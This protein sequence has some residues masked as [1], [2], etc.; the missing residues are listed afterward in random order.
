MRL[1]LVFAAACAWA[2]ATI[3]ARAADPP[4]RA[5]TLFQS[6][7]QAMDRGDY[8]MACAALAESLRLEPAAGTLLNLATCEERSGKLAQALAHFREGRAR[9][10]DGD[11]RVAF[12]EQRIAELSRRVPRLTLALTGTPEAGVT[13]VRDGQAVPLDA[14]GT[15]ALVDPGPHVCVLRAPGRADARVDVTLREGEERTVDLA[16]GP[17]LGA[18]APASASGR[19]QR[20]AGLATGGAG[21]A[22]IAVGT[23]FGFLSKSTYNDARAHC[24]A[25]P[26]SCD[27][28]GVA[29]GK[30][31][32]AQATVATI[33]FIAG[34]ALVVAGAA[35][36]FT[37]PTGAR[38]VIAPTVGSGVG[39]AGAW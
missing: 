17:R 5:D 11:F 14:V 1:A 8:A 27:D 2:L 34:S 39:V 10:A 30:T 18:D 20:V 19:T 22:G 31:A 23:I 38:V 13:I 7:K 29:G 21:L 16:E 9:L 28:Q 25:G 6:G 4:S 33:G 32:H 3:P 12:S 26:A 37:A 35:L 36:Y 24:P 15:A